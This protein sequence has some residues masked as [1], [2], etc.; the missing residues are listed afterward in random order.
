MES[1]VDKMVLSGGVGAEIDARNSLQH[2]RGS[3]SPAA[4]ESGLSPDHRGDPSSMGEAANDAPSAA[5]TSGP[6]PK[7]H[8]GYPPSITVP[9]AHTVGTSPE[10]T[11]DERPTAHVRVIKDEHQA[12]AD[13]AGA[14]DFGGGGLG[15]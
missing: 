14:N 2:G 1:S 3:F 10:E 7:Q 8:S 6:S 13:A 15:V 5:A 4:T 12:A 9:A 11:V